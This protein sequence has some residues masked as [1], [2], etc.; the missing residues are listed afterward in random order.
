[1]QDVV[2]NAAPDPTSD[3]TSDSS[4]DAKRLL[5]SEMRRLRVAIPD[6]PQ[7]AASISAAVL[8]RCAMIDRGRPDG[9]G[10]RVL[11]FIGVGSEPDTEALIAELTERH[12]VALPR[13]EGDH[14][15]AVRYDGDA[16]A[17]GA[18]GIPEPAGPAIDPAT[19]DVVIVPGLAFTRNGRRLGQGGGFYD[20]FLPLVRPDCVTIG[21]CF[22]EQ[23]IDSVPSEPHDRILDV[24]LTDA[25]QE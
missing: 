22:R 6:R 10:L 21:V 15:V 1:M 17:P 24:V 12:C 4:G 16:L 7:R 14:M 19:I 9:I 11:A 5:R 25:V 18:F 3:P 23:V 2:G 8:D 20:R 13:V